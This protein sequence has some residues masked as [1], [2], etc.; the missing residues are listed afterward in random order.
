[1][2]EEVP[3]HLEADV[4]DHTVDTEVVPDTVVEA[5]MEVHQVAMVV[6]LEEDIVVD[7]VD[8]EEAIHHIEQRTIPARYTLDTIDFGHFPIVIGLGNCWK[9]TL[10]ITS[11]RAF[12]R[13][14][15]LGIRIDSK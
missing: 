12:N 10:P 4:V 13:H 6:H 5:D 1:M 3:C 14:N 15:V 2:E 8:E 11:S 9:R 7:F